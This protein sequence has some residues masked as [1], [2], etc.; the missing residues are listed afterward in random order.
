MAE[1]KDFIQQLINQSPVDYS[2]I[3]QERTAKLDLLI[4]LLSNSNR[5]VVL[6]GSKGVGKTTLLNVFQQWRNALWQTCLIQGRADL[7]L[8]QIQMRLSELC[9]ASET[10][11]IFFERQAMLHKKIVLIIDDAGSLPPYLINAI[12]DYAAAYSV[13]NVIFVLTH[14]DLAIR[15]RSDNAIEASHIIEIPPL[16]EQQCGDFLQHLALKSKLHVPIHNITDDMIAELFQKTHGIPEQI[17]AQLPTLIRPKKKSK[18]MGGLVMMLLGLIVVWAV[19]TVW[20]KNTLS[21]ASLSSL[22]TSLIH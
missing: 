4:H 9:P 5:P 19:M 11:T 17:I 1:N 13:L 6:C 2:L 12:I 21:F 14:D 16:S 18:I 8:E 15:N 20:S 10:L 3:T 22:L 7:S